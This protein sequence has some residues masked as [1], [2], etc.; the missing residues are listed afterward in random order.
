MVAPGIFSWATKSLEPVKNSS[1]IGLTRRG[2]GAGELT[3]DTSQC[4]LGFL[5]THNLV[6][7]ACVGGGGLGGGGE[8]GEMEK[9]P[10]EMKT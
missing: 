1:I 8:V 7:E 9:Q 3:A 5:Y 10:F 6:Q 4:L 2:G